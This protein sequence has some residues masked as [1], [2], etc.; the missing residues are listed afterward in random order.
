MAPKIDF[1]S[2]EEDLTDDQIQE[3]LRTAARR[4]KG[5]AIAPH[6]EK[7]RQFPQKY[8]GKSLPCQTLFSY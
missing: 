7:A 5:E 1:N 2:I 4:L 6:H 8:A 3:L